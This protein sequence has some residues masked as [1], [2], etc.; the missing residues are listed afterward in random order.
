MSLFTSRHTVVKC[1]QRKSLKAV[2]EKNTD[3]P[4]EKK[5]DLW[6]T[7]QQQQWMLEGSGIISSKCRE[8]IIDGL[9]PLPRKTI[10]M[11]AK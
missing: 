11:R 3:C 9:D 10:F 8:K 5:T 4:Q 1:R 6:Y 2:R 7:Y